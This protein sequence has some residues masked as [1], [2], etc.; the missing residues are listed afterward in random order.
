MIEFND[1][2]RRYW[3]DQRSNPQPDI[4]VKGGDF[5]EHGGSTYAVLVD[6]EKAVVAVYRV[7]G[8]ANPRLMRTTA[9]ERAQ[10]AA[11]LAEIA[12]R[13]R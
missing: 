11:Q 4:P 3:R 6:S 2:H 1:V 9:D 5:V 8:G 12:R 7:A 13:M 10:L